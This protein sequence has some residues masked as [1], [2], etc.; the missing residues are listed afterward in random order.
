MFLTGQHKNRLKYWQCI[1]A[2]NIEW[3][4]QSTLNK[5]TTLSSME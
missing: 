3:I 1:L 5:N 2:F 4:Y